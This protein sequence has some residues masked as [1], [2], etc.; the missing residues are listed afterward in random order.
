MSTIP[1]QYLQLWF[2]YMEQLQSCAKSFS[3]DV[4]NDIADFSKKKHSEVFLS[5]SP[6]QDQFRSCVYTNAHLYVADSAF[7]KTSTFLDLL[8]YIYS[9]LHGYVLGVFQKIAGDAYS[10]LLPTNFDAT[11]AKEAFPSSDIQQSLLNALIATMPPS[12]F[13]PPKINAFLQLLAADG[14][15]VKDGVDFVTKPGVS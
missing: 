9:P 10:G 6:H 2:R 8:E 1:E 12:W 3:N 11:P 7:T 4:P 14:K 5:S 15:K 13:P